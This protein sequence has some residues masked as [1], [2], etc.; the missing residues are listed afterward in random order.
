MME[1]A[2]HPGLVP[3]AELASTV[4][5]GAGAA[6]LSGDGHE[7]VGVLHGLDRD[8]TPVLLAGPDLVRVLGLTTE[9]DD[10]VVRL[11]VTDLAPLVDLTL[12]RAQ[13]EVAG[14]VRL[15]PSHAVAARLRARSRT[16][17]TVAFASWPGARLLEVDVAEVVLHAGAGCAHLAPEDLR[18][19]L[20]DPVGAHEAELV[21]RLGDDLG[22]AL[23]ELVRSI[24][25]AHHVDG[26]PARPLADALEARVV[27]VDRH[28]LTVLCALPDEGATGCCEHPS[29]STVR[30][31]FPAP[32][33]SAAE[34]ERA[35][36]ALVT[37]GRGCPHGC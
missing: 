10:A 30:V 6:S 19:A 32:V 25:H 8:G 22:A 20:P 18:S 13:V 26:G 34:A 21:Q 28:G 5:A 23:L 14:W 29:R 17:L 12:H 33:A 16:D 27:G 3:A 4:L 1:Y 7:P 31:P 24:G 37:G 36:L 11:E 2:P 9:R 35:A 15:V